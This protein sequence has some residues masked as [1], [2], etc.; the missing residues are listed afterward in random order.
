MGTSTTIRSVTRYTLAALFLCFLSIFLLALRTQSQGQNFGSVNLASPGP[1]GGTTPSTG[2]FTSVTIPSDGVHAQQQTL[3]GQ[4]TGAV[5]GCPANSYCVQAPLSASF[6]AIVDQVPTNAPGNVVAGIGSTPTDGWFLQ[7]TTLSTAGTTLQYSPSIHW[8]G[9][10]W[11]TTATAADNRTDFIS[12]VVPSTG[13]SVTG[14]LHIQA[15]INGGGYSDVAEFQ[16]SGGSFFNATYVTA[17]FS[18]SSF[19][20]F[21]NNNAPTIS[22]GFNATSPSISANNGTAAFIINT[23]TGTAANSGVIGMPGANAGWN[24]YFNN[25]TASAAN[26]GA[27]TVQTASSTNSVTV[28]EQTNSTGAAVN[29]TAGDLIQASCWAY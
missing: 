7:N 24:C 29:F 1:I 28:Q 12:F 18:A 6:T 11:N 26:R 23:G 4:T 14:T 13:S 19:H 16:S 21:Y 25:I 27:N 9:G 10:G 17:L 15:A 3:Y 22:S 5:G 2:K 20:F 8:Q